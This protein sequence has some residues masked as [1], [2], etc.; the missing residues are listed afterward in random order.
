MEMLE[1]V[2]APTPGPEDVSANVTTELVNG[3]D[4][5]ESRYP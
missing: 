4:G 1:R 5:E 2:R 3:Q